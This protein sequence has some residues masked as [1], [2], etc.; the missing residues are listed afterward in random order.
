MAQMTEY[1]ASVFGTAS[2][3]WV[4]EV[5]APVEGWTV[6]EIFAPVTAEEI[7]DSRPKSGTGAGPDGIAPEVWNA[8][9]VATKR[10]LF[11]CLMLWG[12]M[13][14]EML[15]AQTTMIP[16]VSGPLAPGDYRPIT[17]ASVIVRHYHKLLARRLGDAYDFLPAQKGF[18]PGLDGVGDSV[19]RLNA[20]LRKARR[21][22]RAL[23][24]VS[25]DVAK[26]F[27]SVSH[28]AILAVLRGKGSPPALTDYVARCLSR[29]TLRLKWRGDR[30]RAIRM[31]RG[32]RQGDP[33]SPFL[34]NIVMDHVLTGLPER[35]GFPL[36]TP[37]ARIGALAYADDL[38]LFASSEIGARA[39]IAAAESG[40]AEC[41][42]RVN[43]RKSWSLCLNPS[44][45]Q[46]LVKVDS[47]VGFRAAGERVFSVGIADTFDYLGTRFGP[48][49]A[50]EVVLGLDE[51]LHKVHRAPLKPQQKLEVVRDFLLPGTYHEL[52]LG[53]VRKPE[54]SRWDVKVRSFIRGWLRLPHDIANAYLHAP[55]KCGGLALPELARLVPAWRRLRRE[56]IISGWGD[57]E[58][59]ELGGY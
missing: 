39:Q 14:G 35:V 36:G 22:R 23:V 6:E 3:P 28:E 13:P 53:Q 5:V 59:E 54:L 46:K 57:A 27:D 56:R 37:G 30:S 4:G 15:E 8:V 42:L 47:D 11:N 34:F 12:A 1:W 43:P 33:L 20:I 2:E 17:V 16:K 48:F 7:G 19:I 51:K 52:V 18:V 24:V 55:I 31:A 40:L 25:L 44:G 41:G 50:S 9:P 29:S 58:A 10:L 49:G 32:V 38:L 45:R 26:A 21:S